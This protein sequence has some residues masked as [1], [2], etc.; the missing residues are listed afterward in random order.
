MH[1]A[2]LMTEL[3]PGA[4]LPTVDDMFWGN[5]DAITPSEQLTPAERATLAMAIE[6]I[7]QTTKSIF[8][9]TQPQLIHAD[10]HGGNVMWQ[11]ADVAVFDFDDC[12]I[13]LPVQDIA[14]AL[15]YNDTAEQDS[16]FLA[17]YQEIAPLP[18]YTEEEMNVLRLQR[19]IFLL[20]YILETENP[21]HRAMVP[22]YLART[23]ERIHEVFGSKNA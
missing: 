17:G 19:R 12:V 3:V 13:G 2:S 11:G 15:Y 22:K 9:R 8:A 14:V 4:E 5:T 21:E 10:M 7:E 16:A 23:L 18:K 6:Q 1:I 20:S